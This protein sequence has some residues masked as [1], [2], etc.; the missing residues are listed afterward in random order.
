MCE[1]LWHR[2]N[3]SCKYHFLPTIPGGLSVCKKFTMKEADP[4]EVGLVEAPPA[5]E[6]CVAC[7]G[8]WEK[9]QAEEVVEVK[10][11]APADKALATIKPEDQRSTWEVMEN[12]DT[13]QMTAEM[14]GEVLR[15]L[16]ATWPDEDGVPVYQ[17]LYA[18]VREVQRAYANE[19]GAIELPL[20]GSRVEADE[21]TKMWHADQEGKDTKLGTITTGSGSAPMFTKVA[22]CPQCGRRLKRNYNKGAAPDYFCYECRWKGLRIDG[23]VDVEVPDKFARRTARSIAE[24]N[25]LRKLLPIVVVEAFIELTLKNRPE[26]VVLIDAPPGQKKGRRSGGST[27]GYRQPSPQPEPQL[28]RKS[29]QQLTDEAHNRFFAKWEKV[30]AESRWDPALTDADSFRSDTRHAFVLLMTSGEDFQREFPGVEPTTSIRDFGHSMLDFLSAVVD[31][32]FT[33]IVDW[34]SSGTY[35]DVMETKPEG[36][37][38]P[39]PNHG[40]V[41]G[42]DPSPPPQK[43]E[44]AELQE[45]ASMIKLCDNL[46]AVVV[47]AVELKIPGDDREKE[48]KR[49]IVHGGMRTALLKGFGKSDLVSLSLWELQAMAQVLTELDKSIIEWLQTGAY[50]TAN[51]AMPGTATYQR[52]LSGVDGGKEEMASSEVHGS[53]FKGTEDDLPF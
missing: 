27:G 45:Q 13:F 50:L 33:G 40:Q 38:A 1:G 44:V 9:A 42:G 3:K 24:R 18:G 37:P 41:E 49:K 29:A 19:G 26:S 16:I 15:K 4:E 52:I 53:E 48:N 21:V 22:S 17:L 30:W 51:M 31:A 32:R 7:R 36:P 23:V 11:I 46:L 20:S 34:C 39:D 43:P 47:G 25:A 12:I 10:E 5:S 8:E 2:R 35:R 14:H 6:C 28:P